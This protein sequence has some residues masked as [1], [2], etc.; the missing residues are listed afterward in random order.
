M[1]YKFLCLGEPSIP[2]KTR[3]VD[4]YVPQ[5]MDV[6]GT[7]RD[8]RRGRE[9]EGGSKGLVSEHGEI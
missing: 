9:R 5:T 6:G 8:K 7:Y 1:L 2:Y 3:E 4:E